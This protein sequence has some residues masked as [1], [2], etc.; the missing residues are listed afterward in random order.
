MY[1]TFRL[2]VTVV[3]RQNSVMGREFFANLQ[4]VND[5]TWPALMVSINFGHFYDLDLKK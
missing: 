2:P 4:F 5:K 3:C 1:A